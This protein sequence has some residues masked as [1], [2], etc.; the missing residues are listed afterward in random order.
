MMYESAAQQ[1]LCAPLGGLILVSPYASLR[2]VVKSA[3]TLMVP[4]LSRYCGLAL[5]A[6]GLVSGDALNTESNAKWLHNT[7]TLIIHGED[8]DLIPIQQGEDVFNSIPGDKSVFIKV[9]GLGHDFDMDDFHSIF[10]GEHFGRWM[11]MN[12][13]LREVTEPTHR[14][15]RYETT[16]KLQGR[17][18]F[19]T[20]VQLVCPGPPRHPREVPAPTS[21]AQPKAGRS[22]FG[23]C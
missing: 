21:Q 5:C 23:L 17:T 9:E 15:L 1:R 18:D 20:T 8:D 22:C 4:S 19:V 6:G 13:G 7:A 10:F 11:T 12:P 16:K 14:D 2:S 3:V